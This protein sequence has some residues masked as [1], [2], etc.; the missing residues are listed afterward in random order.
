MG[1][2][3]NTT[4]P[5]DTLDAVRTLLQDVQAPLTTWSELVDAAAGVLAD[6][7]PPLGLVTFSPFAELRTPEVVDR[8]PASQ[9]LARQRVAPAAPTADIAVSTA[10]PVFALPPRKRESTALAPTVVRNTA[11]PAVALDQRHAAQQQTAS[12]DQDAAAAQALLSTMT[13]FA[14]VTDTLLA[15]SAVTGA[16]QATTP[17][18]HEATAPALVMAQHRQAVPGGELSTASVDRGTPLPA[19]QPP[20]VGKLQM[21]TPL[22]V[23]DGAS[24]QTSISQETV[25]TAD[26][27]FVGTM[28][29]LANLTDTLLT[30]AKA[31]NAVHTAPHTPE[32]GALPSASTAP[33]P[34]MPEQQHATGFGSSSTWPTVAKTAHTQAPL[35]PP[36]PA[37]TPGITAEAAREGIPFPEGTGPSVMMTGALAASP[38]LSVEALSVETLAGGPLAPPDAWTLAQL[39][40]DVLAEEARRHGVDLS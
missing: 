26:G 17:D 32:K 12:G 39:I 31:G 19:A 37:T 18:R 22:A 10:K 3:S 35:S 13:Q 34:S 4:K 7:D 27:V 21:P 23:A 5:P 33:S 36:T 8:A 40:N 16:E 28:A 38:A 29:L 6:L 11:S 20:G 30:S 2:P 25:A 1:E 15:G 14:T 9:P 24:W